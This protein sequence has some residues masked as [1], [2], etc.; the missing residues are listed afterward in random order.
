MFRKKKRNVKIKFKYTVVRDD[1]C[2]KFHASDTLRRRMGKDGRDI[3]EAE[4]RPVC[5]PPLFHL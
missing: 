2:F 5:L 1:V 4:S 3:I